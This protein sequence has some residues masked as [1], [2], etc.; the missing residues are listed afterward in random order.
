MGASW[1]VQSVWGAEHVGTWGGGYWGWE[2]EGGLAEKLTHCFKLK[3]KGVSYQIGGSPAAG[4]GGRW[5][6]PGVDRA[7]P[8]TGPGVGQGRAVDRAL[9]D[10]ACPVS[11]Q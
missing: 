4:E 10:G 11:T 6:G 8:W 3:V 1:P 5:T 2:G 9:P 7:G